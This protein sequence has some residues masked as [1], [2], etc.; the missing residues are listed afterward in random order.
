MRRSTNRPTSSSPQDPTEAYLGAS[1]KQILRGS[2]WSKSTAAVAILALTLRGCAG[3]LFDPVLTAVA[4][5]VGDIA[6]L[7]LGRQHDAR[8]NCPGGFVHA[9][10]SDTWVCP[11]AAHE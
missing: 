11:E 10:P 8:P 2:R 5:A 7:A 3:L 6:D 9:M 1:S 4:Y